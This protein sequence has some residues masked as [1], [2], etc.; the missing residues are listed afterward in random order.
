MDLF[1]I[2]QLKVIIELTSGTC[3]LN[4]IFSGI[5]L[6]IRLCLVTTNE[7]SFIAYSI[8]RVTLF[9]TKIDKGYMWL[10]LVQSSIEVGIFS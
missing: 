3:P 9:E 6:S 10:V 7:T 5:L 8:Q 1:W 2:S 4:E